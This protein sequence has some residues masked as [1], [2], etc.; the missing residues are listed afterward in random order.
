MDKLKNSGFYK[1]RFFIRPEEFEGVLKRFEH[2]QAQFHLINYAQTEHDL[3]QVYEAYQTFYH[4]F[5]AEKKGM[6]VPLSL[7]IPFLLRLIMKAPDFSREM[8]VS[9]FHITDNGQRMNCRV[10]CYHFLKA[11]K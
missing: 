7:F 9:I 4:Y 1:L 3:K 6:R 5:T 8:R 11:F 2:K 10:S